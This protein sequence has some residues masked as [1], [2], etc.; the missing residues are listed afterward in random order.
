MSLSRSTRNDM[1][2]RQGAVPAYLQRLSGYSRAPVTRLVARWVAVNPRPKK[3]PLPRAP[4]A[5]LRA[6]TRPLTCRC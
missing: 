2:P 6:A 3:N 4:S 1:E 5:L